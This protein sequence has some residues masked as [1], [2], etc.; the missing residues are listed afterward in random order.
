[1]VP[2]TMPA[3]RTTVSPASDWVSGR[4]TG[5]A[6]ATAASKYKSTCAFSAAC[7]NSPV[8]VAN[9]ALFAV[10]TDLPCSSAVRIALRDGSTGPINSTTMSTSSR[11]DELFD[12]VGEQVDGDA[13]VRGD[14]T[15]PDAAQH[16]RRADTGREI[17][18]ALL[19]DADNLAAD[20]AEPEYRYADWLFVA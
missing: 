14:A 7:A 4:M 11:D 5:I 16:K 10:T 15:D 19:D 6:P 2:L 13:T 9:N 18:R 12:V 8:E 3:T 1:M 17:V 20:V